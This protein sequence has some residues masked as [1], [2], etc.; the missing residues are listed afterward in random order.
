M[1]HYEE[2]ALG[3]GVEAYSNGAR[4]LE[5]KTRHGHFSSGM[6]VILYDDLVRVTGK[7]ARLKRIQ[8]IDSATTPMGASISK[9]IASQPR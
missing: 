8:S 4:I 3:R 6:R 7:G 5:C 9:F 1:S 2:Y